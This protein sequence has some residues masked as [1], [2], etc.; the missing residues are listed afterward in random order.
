MTGLGNVRHIEVAQLWVQ[1]KVRNGEIRLVKVVGTENLA[2]AL[3]KY[4]NG[5][6]LEKHVHGL[7][8][9]WSE[10]RHEMMPQMGA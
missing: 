6:E 5:D 1:E 3:T 8:G 2:D 9:R 7:G 4:V 10:G